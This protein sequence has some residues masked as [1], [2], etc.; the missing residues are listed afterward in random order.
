[1]PRRL[2]C[3]GGASDLEHCASSISG[4]CVIVDVVV[5][6]VDVF[7]VVAVNV[8]VIVDVFVIVVIIDDVIVDVLF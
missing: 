7:V 4:N 3:R 6:M 2:G 5:L 1:M 8:K